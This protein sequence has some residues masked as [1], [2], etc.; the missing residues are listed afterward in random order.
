MD[1]ISAMLGLDIDDAQK[2]RMLANSLRDRKDAADRFALSTISNISGGAQGEQASIMA[3]AEQGG[4]LRKSLQDRE[5]QAEQAR[6]T[7]SLSAEQGGL[8]RAS[9]ERIAANR[10]ASALGI[11]ELNQLGDT[12]D[13][14]T[15]RTNRL[16][17]ALEKYSKNL[18]T[19]NLPRALSSLDKLEQTLVALL[20]AD[21]EGN[22]ATMED[23]T[24]AVNG[25]M[26]V[27]GVGGLMNL[28]Y[29]GGAATLGGDL[30]DKTVGGKAEGANIRSARQALFNQEIKLQSGAAVT[31]P[32]MLRNQIALGSEVWNNDKDFLAALPRIREG[33]QKVMKNYEHG[34]G[35][36]V[37]DIYNRRAAGERL[38]VEDYLNGATPGEGESLDAQIARLKAELGVTGD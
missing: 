7:R 2:T 29:W 19:S 13:D 25:G 28:P 15:S 18:Q 38:T 22:P 20:P 16:E 12:K 4:R 27:P 17:T 31:L 5:Q 3:G 26:N 8:D 24:A 21:A 10:D 14:V 36:E 1:D 6:L 35:P 33:I 37:V 11:A 23:V 34:A 32:E 9:R 30:L